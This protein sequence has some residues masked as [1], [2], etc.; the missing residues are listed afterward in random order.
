[1]SSEIIGW[2]S[3]RERHRGSETAVLLRTSILVMEGG[4]P[5]VDLTPE[6]RKAFPQQTSTFTHSSF[7]LA[8]PLQGGL[9][10]RATAQ[11]R[12]IRQ[13]LPEDRSAHVHP[14]VEVLTSMQRGC[15]LTTHCR[16]HG[17]RLRRP[18][19]G[20]DPPPDPAPD[21][22]SVIAYRF[23]Q[24]LMLG[25]RLERAANVSANGVHRW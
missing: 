16:G 17:A 7:R 3:L 15:A 8:R 20:L 5:E 4:L 2:G 25:R 11:R 6:R 12:P 21:N 1:M 10:S 18:P 9:R 22:T 24:P 23:A 13:D 14:L 19:Q